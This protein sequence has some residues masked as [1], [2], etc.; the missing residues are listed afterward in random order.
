[1]SDHHSRPVDSSLRTAVSLF[2]G[3]VL[4]WLGVRS[5][6]VDAG[7][8]FAAFVSYRHVE[9][10]RSWA[11]WIQRS[12]E[13]FLVP[14]KLLPPGGAPALGPVFRDE[15]E[16]SAGAELPPRIQ[17][18]L[19]RSGAL[20]VVCSPR[21]IE[22]T[23]VNEEV[24]YFRSLGP[25]KPILPLLIEGEPGT[26]YPDSLRE[27]AAG[28]VVS[29][30]GWPLAADVRK[31]RE[32]I[33]PRELKRRELQRILAPL[34]GVTFDQLRDRD[35][36]R[37]IARLRWLAGGITAITLL[38]SLLA[39]G[40]ELYR[41][42]AQSNL[43]VMYIEAG[44]R[45]ASERD[46]LAAKVAFAASLEAADSVRARSRLLEMDA[47]GV[48]VRWQHAG[49]A[50]TRY[51]TLSRDGATA[52]VSGDYGIVSAVDVSDGRVLWNQALRAPVAAVTSDGN[53]QVVAI[54][55]FGTAHWLSAE[56]GTVG[57]IT[58]PG[59]ALRPLAA[60]FDVRGETLLVLN[61]AGEM[62][63]HGRGARADSRP[64]IVG[65]AIEAAALRPE[66]NRMVV[67]EQTGSAS[68]LEIEQCAPL[69]RWRA[70]NS[71]IS[72]VAFTADGSRVA[73]WGDGN[74][75]NG[76]IDHTIALWASDGLTL[77]RRLSA[78][79]PIPG[80]ASL[81]TGV[82]S[83]ELAATSSSELVAWKGGE[84]DP[85]LNTAV[86]WS[87][88]VSF[89]PSGDR[90]MAI[91]RQGISAWTGPNW[92]RET[93]HQL[94]GGV[95]QSLAVS[96]SGLEVFALDWGGAVRVLDS[97]TGTL[98][99]ILSTPSG[100]SRI[101]LS[102][103]G[104]LLAVCGSRNEVLSAQTGAR[105][106]TLASEASAS[107]IW[108]GQCLAWHPR[109][110]R[111]VVAR[112]LLPM[113][114]ASVRTEAIA[115][116]ATPILSAGASFVQSASRRYLAV[117]Y[118]DQVLRI[119]DLEADA[120]VASHRLTMDAGL[121]TGMAVSN[122]GRLVA[123]ATADAVHVRGLSS[124]AVQLRYPDASATMSFGGGIAFSDGDVRL[125]VGGTGGALVWSLDSGEPKLE[126]VI[127]PGGNTFRRQIRPY[128]SDLAFTPDGYGLV[129][130]DDDGWIHATDIGRSELARTFRLGAGV[131]A[132]V[133][134]SPAGEAIFVAVR[135]SGTEPGNVTVL[136]QSSGI[137]QAR[138][139]LPPGS[140]VAAIAPSLQRRRVYV[141]HSS[142]LIQQ[143]DWG[144]EG[145][146][147][148]T[149]RTWTSK[150]EQI[151][152]DP[153]ES[154]LAVAYAPS[155]AANAPAM[156]GYV[157]IEDGAVTTTATVHSGAVQSMRF[158]AAGTLL[159]AGYDRAAKN[160][161]MAGAMIAEYAGHSGTVTSVGEDRVAKRIY[162]SSRDGFVRTFDLGGKLR[163]QVLADAAC[164][165]D[166]KGER[167]TPWPLERQFIA[168][169]CKGRLLFYDSE[170]GQVVRSLLA[171]NSDAWL[172]YMEL[173]TD[174]RW[175]VTGAHR[176]EVRVWDLDALRSLE[177]LSVTEWV[178]RAKREA[179]RSHVPTFERL[180]SGVSH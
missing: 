84:V 132:A 88:F 176:A 8:S 73:T 133:A 39:L 57:R 169:G 41:R 178:R 158:T 154:I 124:D 75:V 134:T 136:H 162:T 27:D 62:V 58:R 26:A 52:F 161:S 107:K 65:A 45:L 29:S 168:S 152:L 130:A 127:R 105:V 131:S 149:I 5:V 4:E 87:P 122:S 28:Q 98:K 96:P 20:I 101:S 142:G 66:L 144:R 160:W 12:I 13:A 167:V 81:T 109:D 113:T 70:H 82:G 71:G 100:T 125:A 146:N 7:R 135:S 64:C 157:R 128:I 35:S 111:S 123:I 63:Q 163:S 89:S 151:A 120:V 140:E 99:R 148:R 94:S 97:T 40:L 55:A 31:G 34:I 115:V 67:G 59:R 21:T 177:Q 150:V 166:L 155:D 118:P 85:F 48:R 102:A 42:D 139:R 173:Q 72:A 24:R 74:R 174:Q 69:A 116:A 54:D 36:E 92:I 137:V 33:S 44:E 112:P 2:S 95:G 143:W 153:T 159:T 170:S 103:D 14:R 138:L 68:V 86:N 91:G 165:G 114:S 129:F 90:L 11:I 3:R 145:D 104:A 106:A 43:A 126:A 175:L 156:L 164:E 80:N 1:M 16:L 46:L 19:Q 18:A 17:A 180:G 56:T 77:H 108:L 147:L 53:S 25:N 15:E 22:S 49:V 9:P 83:L 37:R 119:V 47:H 30:A 121:I 110:S 10:D 93:K 76:L 172:L 23:W 117:L 51:G 50:G 78:P 60:A 6:R 38:V 79:L 179:G 32:G 141:A 171:H 61:A